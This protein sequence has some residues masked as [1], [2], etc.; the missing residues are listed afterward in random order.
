[1]TRKGRETEPVRDVNGVPE[2]PRGRTRETRQPGTGPGAARDLEAIQAL[3]AEALAARSA[4]PAR[5]PGPWDPIV[6][7]RPIYDF[8]PRPPVPKTYGG[9]DYVPDTMSDGWSSSGITLR[10]ASVRG[11]SHRYQGTSR[12]DHAEA[13]FHQGADGREWVVFAV[14]DGVGSAHR[15]EVGAIDATQAAIDAVVGHLEERRPPDWDAIVDAAASHLAVRAGY[16]LR[17]AQPSF[18]QVADLLAT[19]LVVGVVTATPRGLEASVAR[20]GDSGAWVLGR[21]GYRPLFGLKHDPRA[22]V[23]SSAVA[24]LPQVPHPVASATVTVGPDE[25]LLLATDGLGDPLGDGTGQVGEL[26][27]RHLA[28]PPPPRGL[29][30]LLDFSRDTFDDDRTLLALWPR[31]APE[32]P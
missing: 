28:T 21:G 10:L 12:Q 13:L 19:T 8:E 3:E 24:A 25:V 26:F 32:T 31:R 16:L 27:A 4:P 30:H 18:A 14:A 2:P 20:V 7:G 6:V 17:T 23:A 5:E 29:A 9:P 11:Y 22:A 15:S 1:M